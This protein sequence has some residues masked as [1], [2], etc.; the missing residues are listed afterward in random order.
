M[1]TL[2]RCVVLA[3]VILAPGL[4]LAQEPGDDDEPEVK[5][6]DDPLPKA[7]ELDD[8]GEPVVK[9]SAAHRY[10]RADYPIEVTLRPLTLARGQ[11]EA[12]LDLPFVTGA[13]QN[14]QLLRA[15]FG[16]TVD[17]QLG[18]SYNFGLLRFDPATGEDTYE[19]GRAFSVD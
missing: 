17:L 13:G 8:D 12:S 7:P 19:A 4:A 15:G 3:L 14:S 16:A 18:L 9:G 2:S 10:T 11:L 6:I 5:P 1:R